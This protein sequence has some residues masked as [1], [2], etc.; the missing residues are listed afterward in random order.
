[1]YTIYCDRK[2]HWTPRTRLSDFR[3]HHLS[4]RA[5]SNLLSSL[6]WRHSW[7]I[8][9]YIKFHPLVFSYAARLYYSPSV[10]VKALKLLVMVNLKALTW[11]ITMLVNTCAFSRKCYS[12]RFLASKHPLQCCIEILH[13]CSLHHSIFSMCMYY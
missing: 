2:P 13:P 1:M 5:T 7:F 3:R 11:K 9:V 6:Y 10:K 12:L 8:Y 4:V